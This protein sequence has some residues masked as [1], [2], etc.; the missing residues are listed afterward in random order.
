VRACG[1]WPRIVP[2]CEARNLRGATARVMRRAAAPAGDVRKTSS[3]GD[4]GGC[5][6]RGPA[7]HGS[8][9]VVRCVRCS[10]PPSESEACRGEGPLFCRASGAPAGAAARRGRG[11]LR[12]RDLRQLP[13]R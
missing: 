8:W 10:R 6:A 2:A 4:R 12:A 7:R 11:R 1:T 3:D 9:N 5:I 13:R